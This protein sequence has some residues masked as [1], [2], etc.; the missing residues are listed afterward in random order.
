[1]FQ[2]RSKTRRLS[3]KMSELQMERCIASKGDF[4][5]RPIYSRFP[6]AS[7][8][9]VTGFIDVSGDVLS[10]PNPEW[11]RSLEQCMTQIASFTIICHRLQKQVTETKYTTSGWNTLPHWRSWIAT[12]L[13]TFTNSTTLLAETHSCAIVTQALLRLIADACRSCSLNS[14]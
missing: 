5:L 2:N 6:L 7:T 10:S 8:S 4:L 9:S 3:T 13:G 14:K 11:T 12:F 1:M